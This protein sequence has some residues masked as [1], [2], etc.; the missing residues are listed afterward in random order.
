MQRDCLDKTR[1]F[2]QESPETSVKRWFF[3]DVLLVFRALKSLAEVTVEL[4]SSVRLE[5]EIRAV[6]GSLE[7]PG[8]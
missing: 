8:W 3:L 2:A 5:L 4:P 1:L 6:D 7:S